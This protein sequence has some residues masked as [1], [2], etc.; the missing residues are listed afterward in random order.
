VAVNLENQ[1]K[2]TKEV[3]DSLLIITEAKIFRIKRESMKKRKGCTESMKL[4]KKAIK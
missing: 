1:D 4:S 3:K 2:N